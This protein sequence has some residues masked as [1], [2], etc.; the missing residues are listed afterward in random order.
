M[1]A[2][3]AVGHHVAA[4]AKGRRDAPTLHAS[5]GRIVRIQASCV[6]FSNFDTA[7]IL[8]VASFLA[9]VAESR[10]RCSQMAV[11]RTIDE[12]GEANC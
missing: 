1:A 8:R 5:S 2:Q 12:G 7:I 11:M 6:A 10:K 4:G 3:L 9:F